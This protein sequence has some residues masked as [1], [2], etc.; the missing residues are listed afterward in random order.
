[1]KTST[2]TLKKLPGV[3]AF[4]R[5]HVVSDAE[6]FNI[7]PDKEST[8]VLVVRHGIRGTQ[9]VNDGKGNENPWIKSS[10]TSESGERSVSNIQTTDSAKVDSD[11]TGLLVRFEMRFLNIEESLDSCASSDKENQRETRKMVEDFLQRAKNSRG[12]FE[13]ACRYARNIGNGR[14]LWR[15]RTMA[16][17][18]VVDVF[19]KYFSKKESREDRRKI[20]TFNVALKVPTNEFGDYIQEE[21]AVAQEIL[22]QMKGESLSSLVVEARIHFGV[23]GSFEVFPS[24]NY[25]EKKR[26]DKEGTT[27]SLYNLKY[28]R[29][30]D[31]DGMQVMGRAAI[32]DQKIFNAI[33]T[34]DTWYPDY[35][36]VGR[37]IAVEPLGASL[38]L[39]DFYRKG[40]HSSFEIALRLPQVDPDSEEGMFMIAAI[41]RGG[42]YGTSDKDNEKNTKKKT[43]EES[44][45]TE[46]MA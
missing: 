31:D 18:I 7:Y 34:I 32:R 43:D 36:E 23:S 17:S 30:R 10:T 22:H 38:S 45:G 28:S 1:M 2:P 25:V 33:R 37:P 11:A 13:V 20:A 14:W 26:T 35:R 27:R 9:N 41:E 3:M 6:M 4:K 40:K 46:D 12:I 5:G 24:Q 42:V 21:N 16:S 39:Q 29:N 8:P 44:E 15:N 19:E